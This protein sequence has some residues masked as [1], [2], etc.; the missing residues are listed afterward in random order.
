MCENLGIQANS[1]QAIEI[2]IC[3]NTIYNYH[4]QASTRLRYQG[5]ENC[6]EDKPRVG[7]QICQ[8]LL[9]GIDN[10]GTT[11]IVRLKYPD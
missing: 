10:R 6:L 4:Y 11:D 1:S 3:V 9:A 8:S 7:A 2:M 5:F